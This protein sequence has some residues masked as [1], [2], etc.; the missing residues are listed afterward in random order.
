M[1]M[2]MTTRTTASVRAEPVTPCDV[3]VGLVKLREVW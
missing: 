1:P 2:R 3:V